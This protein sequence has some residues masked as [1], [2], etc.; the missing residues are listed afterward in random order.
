MNKNNVFDSNE[1]VF[2]GPKP[3]AWVLAFPE[4]TG[5]VWF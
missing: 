1:H 2:S 4:K 3:L 5:D